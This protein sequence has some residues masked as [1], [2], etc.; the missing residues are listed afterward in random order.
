MKMKKKIVFLGLLTMLV[1]S[2]V[3]VKPAY[4]Q[5]IVVGDSVPAGQVLDQ[6]VV[7]TGTDVSIDGKVNGDVVAIGETFTLN[8]EIVGNLIVLCKTANINGT[9]TGNVFNG[10]LQLEIGPD[11]DLQQDVFNASMLVVTKPGSVIGRDFYTMTIF[12][13]MLQGKI[14]RHVTSLSG[15]VPLVDIIGKW[16]QQFNLPNINIPFL[17]RGSGFSQPVVP[18]I[19][20]SLIAPASL[21]NAL[22]V[23]YAGPV[24]FFNGVDIVN[25]DMLFSFGQQSTGFN[26][27]SIGSWLLDRLRDLVLLLIFGGLFMLLFPK[28]FAQ[29]SE[30]IWE[31]PLKSTGWGFLAFIFIVS[32]FVLLLVV[33]VPV[34]LFFSWLSLDTLTVFSAILGYT[35]LIFAFTS[36]ILYAIYITAALGSYLAGLRGFSRFAPKVTRFRFLLLL[37]GGIVF[38]LLRAIPYFGIILGIWVSFLGVGAGWLVLSD[39]RRRVKEPAHELYEEKTSDLVEP[40]PIMELGEMEEIQLESEIL[41][42]AADEVEEVIQIDESVEES[43]SEEEK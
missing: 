31:K 40:A 14:D 15:I 32:A 28:F 24:G 37:A 35:G 16:L 20:N 9:V 22:P 21:A 27:G 42:E 6:N 23:R 33:L 43:K 3:F 8:G 1:V 25:Q 2:F 26:W 11:A 18:S 39:R 19:A 41:T 5:G 13:E 4:A 7:L 29:T 30:T 17:N 12:G 34:L 10:A 38:V 36:F